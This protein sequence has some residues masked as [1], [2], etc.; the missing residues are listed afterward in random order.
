MSCH[1]PFSLLWKHDVTLV[2]SEN[3]FEP[4]FDICNDVNAAYQYVTGFSW[5]TSRTGLWTHV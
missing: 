2:F 4:H 1:L 5:V 3:L